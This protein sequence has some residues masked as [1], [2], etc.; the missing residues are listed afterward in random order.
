[1]YDDVGRIETEGRIT[2]IK[3]KMTSWTEKAGKKSPCVII[4]DGL[5]MLL[6]P[7]NEVGRLALDVHLADV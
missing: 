7:E 3:D 1:M 2:T 6:P 4:L 5:D